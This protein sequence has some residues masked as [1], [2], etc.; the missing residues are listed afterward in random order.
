MGEQSVCKMRVALLFAVVC[1][2]A[3]SSSAEELASESLSAG[4][5]TD[6]LGEAKITTDA[7]KE[8]K[9]AADDKARAKAAREAPKDSLD[10]VHSADKLHEAVKQTLVEEEKLYSLMSYNFRKGAKGA[11]SYVDYYVRHM[12]RAMMVSTVNG[13]MDMQGST[14]CVSLESTNFPGYFLSSTDKQAAQL[15]KADGSQGFNLRASLC[16]QPGLSDKDAVSL[17]FLGQKGQF[18][19]H[20]GYSLFACKEGDKGECAASSR[21]SSFNDDATFYLKA[22]LFMGRCNGPAKTTDCTCFPGF[23]GEDCSMTCPGRERKGTVVKVCTGQGD[24]ALSKEGVAECKCQSVCDCKKGFMGKLCQY[25]CPGRG[26]NEY[27]TGH[28]SCFIKEA[29][30]A[31]KQP[32]RAQC[33]C[34]DG[35][36]GFTC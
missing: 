13:P 2:I 36:K 8:A 5:L 11:Y 26:K 35:F 16:I 30:L 3:L 34:N 32:K 21:K 25:E 9:Q 18:L 31:K 4:G 14:G 29:D 6:T 1:A 24:C 23:L 12:N 20:S 27:C 7:E 33:T 19:R 17:E 28:G 15:L 10:K 22:G